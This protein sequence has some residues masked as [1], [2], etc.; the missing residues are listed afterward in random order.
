MMI[1]TGILDGMETQIGLV[2]QGVEA[3]REL[4]ENKHEN[5]APL[6]GETDLEQLE[7]RVN[8]LEERFHSASQSIDL[9]MASVEKMVRNIIIP[10]KEEPKE[11][12]LTRKAT[13]YFMAPLPRYMRTAEQR[14]EVVDR[15]VKSGLTGLHI[16]GQTDWFTLDGPMDFQQ[17][18]VQTQVCEETFQIIADL[19]ERL[20]PLDGE[21][22]IWLWGDSDWHLN[23]IKLQGPFGPME[24]MVYDKIDSYFSNNEGITIGIG[25]DCYEWLTREHCKQIVDAISLPVCARGLNYEQYNDL[26][27]FP[28]IEHKHHT[29]EE[30]EAFRA[31]YPSARRLI[32][33]DRCRQYTAGQDH[34]TGTG[35][36]VDNDRHF[37]RE[38]Q[39]QVYDDCIRLGIS[40]IFGKLGSGLDDAGSLVFH[41][42]FNYRETGWQP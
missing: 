16:V 25:W 9:R 22:H 27:D 15:M 17:L 28:S 13:Q 42:P 2:M 1:K 41:Q 10:P 30:L 37:T 21:I 33:E 19:Y 12:Q 7:E 14:A 24:L 26:C 6:P 18:G 32:T 8:Q 4:E 38:R 23:P 5:A 3:L 11:P 20:R 40:G 36:Y 31:R 39:Q 35:V 29:T 34:D